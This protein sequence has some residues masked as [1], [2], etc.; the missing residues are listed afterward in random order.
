ML[1]V[2]NTIPSWRYLGVLLSLTSDNRAPGLGLAM[3][4]ISSGVKQI[5]GEL[6]VVG[7]CWR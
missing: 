5:S 7:Q 6:D 1:E 2:D 3:L 4:I